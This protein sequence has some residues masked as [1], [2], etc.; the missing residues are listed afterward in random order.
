MNETRQTVVIARLLLPAGRE[1]LERRF[2]LVEGGLDA[3]RAQLME[4]VPGAA[5]IVADPTVPIDGE[6]LDAAGDS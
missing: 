1:P 6:V 5:A 3:G 2:N 4:M